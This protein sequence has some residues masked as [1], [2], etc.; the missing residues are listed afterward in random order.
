MKK[1]ARLAPIVAPAAA[2]DVVELAAAAGVK[3]PRRL[4]ALRKPSPGK[5]EKAS[6]SERRQSQRYSPY[7]AQP[8]IRRAV[9]EG[10]RLPPLQR[11]ATDE[12]LNSPFDS[13][14]LAT[15]A[16][17]PISARTRGARWCGGGRPAAAAAAPA[18]ATTTAATAAATAAPA[19]ARRRWPAR[20]ARPGVDEQARGGACAAAASR[21]GAA[22]LARGGGGGVDGARAARLRRHAAA[23]AARRR[24]GAARDRP[25]AA[26]AH[27][28]ARPRHARA[29]RGVRRR[30]RP[31]RAV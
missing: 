2:R 3:V 10:T 28:F 26:R 18:A 19:P 11:R 25:A 12:A 6:P 27:R 23:A 31:V 7:K 5:M 17:A 29:R 16:D 20:H 8:K 14:A 4:Q 15:P 13:I 1:A 21:G 22:A 9:P 24:R 30:R